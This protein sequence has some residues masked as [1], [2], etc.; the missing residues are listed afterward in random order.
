MFA[1]RRLKELA[2]ARR[3]LVLQGDLHRSLLRLETEALRERLAGLA[4][5]RD[6][7]WS[8]R[9]VWVA[10]AVL[11]GVLAVSRWRRLLGWAPAAV[12]AYR[13]FRRFAAK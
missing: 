11:A 12:A 13:W 10:G 7:T 3:L 4:G 1:G 2:D 5:T 9:P 6:P 8:G